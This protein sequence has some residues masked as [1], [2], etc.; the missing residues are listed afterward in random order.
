MEVHHHIGRSS[1]AN[2]QL[3]VWVLRAVSAK[4]ISEKAARDQ[5]MH[6]DAQTA[7]IA[8]CHH[9]GGFHGM[10]ELANTDGHLLHKIAARLG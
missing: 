7:V 2:L 8:A 3:E 4:Q 5:G 9:A 6:A 10:V 1:L